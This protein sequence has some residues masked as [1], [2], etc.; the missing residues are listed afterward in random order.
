MT[1]HELTDD[2][3]LDTVLRC[4]GCGA[5]SRYTYQPQPEHV[6]PVAGLTAYNEFVQWALADVDEHHGCPCQAC[7]QINYG[8]GPDHR[9][10]CQRLGS[11]GHGY[12]GWVIVDL[13]SGATMSTRATGYRVLYQNREEAREAAAELRAG[14]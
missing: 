12:Q 4:T 3:T 5:E 1:T 8:D 11:D 10:T 13:S 2:G 14:D 9:E 6:G 7:G